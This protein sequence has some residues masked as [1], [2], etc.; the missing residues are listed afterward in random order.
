MA[1]AAALLVIPSRVVAAAED[2]NAPPSR[3]S[4][5]NSLGVEFGGRGI[6]YSLQY[7]RAISRRLSTGIGYMW[8]PN[9]NPDRET[10]EPSHAALVP[11][12]ATL[13]VLDGPYTPFLTA[14]GAPCYGCR[15]DANVPRAGTRWGFVPQAGVGFEW[16]DENRRLLRITAYA[17]RRPPSWGNDW[18]FW[19]GLYVG[20]KAGH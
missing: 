4:R 8:F 15:P 1:L 13:H 20:R 17:M 5:P 16:C 12:S 6:L 18:R 7:D 3:L 10:G 14:I 19:L 9:V 2:E 11:L